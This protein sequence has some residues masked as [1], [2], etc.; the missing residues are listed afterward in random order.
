MILA[1]DA[2]NTTVHFGLCDRR[3]VCFAFHLPTGERLTAEDYAAAIAAQ[4]AR[5]PAG[6]AT[7]EG[8]IISSVVPPLLPPLRAAIRQ[9]TGLTA[10]EVTP[11]LCTGLRVMLDDPSQ[12]AGDLVAGAVAAAHKYTLPAIV[13]DVGTAA[14]VSVVDGQRRF[15]GGAI[16]SGPVTALHALSQRAALL[17]EVAAGAP[18]RLIGTNTED[19]MRSGF[20]YGAA[21]MIDEYSRRVEEQLGCPATVVLTGGLSS[22]LADGCRRRVVVDETLV[23]E[24]LYLLYGM[25]G[26]AGGA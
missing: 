7:V 8:A 19:C 4:L 16:M 15:L 25:N 20:F 12:L 26:S 14:T 11:R 6:E 10:M 2:G 23:L 22:L 24:G 17:P 3:G 13:W 5:C 18:T 1:V 21:C 9:C